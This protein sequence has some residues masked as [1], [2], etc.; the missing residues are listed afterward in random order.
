MIHQTFCS[1][2]HYQYTLIALLVASGLLCGLTAAAQTGGVVIATVDAE[3]TAGTVQYV[4]RALG[5]AEANQADLFLLEL[6]TPGGLLQ[7]TEEISRLLVDSPVPSAVYV[8]K[9]AGWAFSAGVYILLS[10]DTTAS[11]PTASIGA[12]TPVTGNGGLAGDKVTNASTQ[13]LTSLAERSNRDAETVRSFVTDATTIN[14]TTG[15]ELGLID[16]L[17]TSTDALLVTLGVERSEMTRL[18]PSTTDNILSF[19]SLPYLVP[20]LLSL[21]ALGIFLL[22]RTGEIESFGLIGVVF[23]TL[24]LWGTGAIAISTLGAILLIIGVGLLA[25]EF[26]F[27]PGF[28]VVG[29]VG[30]IA[31]L[32]AM[33]TFANEPLFPSYFTSSVFYVV[34]G[35]WAGVAVVLFLLGKWSISAQLQP[36]QVGSEALYGRVVEVTA[37]LSPTGR[38]L[39][40]GESYL[41]R[42]NTSTVVPAGTPVTIVK[43]EGNTILV[44]ELTK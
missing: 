32:L 15:F 42:T 38:V 12:A 31:L 6:N 5:E 13:W 8:Y 29:G 41:A 21:G 1:L 2:R 19:L 17:A 43:I 37:A 4:A 40:D 25:V 9:D 7:A 36:V 34:L 26:L 44:E 23:L 11:Q 14:G 28:G 24:G 30:V 27:S 10:A 20:L 3:I 39:V 18:A 35:V 16:E 33:V 22:F